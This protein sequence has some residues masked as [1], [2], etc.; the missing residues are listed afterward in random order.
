MRGKFAREWYKKGE[1][2]LNKYE[3]D[4][5]DSGL[6]FESFI[7]LWIALT[8]AAKEYC[9]C[10]NKDFKKNIVENSTDK[11]EILHWANVRIEQIIKILKE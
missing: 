10:N 8:V 9:A 2:L 1:I 7:Y 5:R 3:L 4:N 11:Q 6:V